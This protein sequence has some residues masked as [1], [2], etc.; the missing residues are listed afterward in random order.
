MQ[1]TTRIRI[2][3]QGVRPSVR[4]SRLSRERKPTRFLSSLVDVRVGAVLLG[5]C[6][7]RFLGGP[8]HGEAHIVPSMSPSVRAMEGIPTFYQPFFLSKPMV[9]NLHIFV[10][11]CLVE[12]PARLPACLSLSMRS[13]CAIGKHAPPR[14]APA[15]TGSRF[16]SPEVSGTVTY[17]LSEWECNC[18]RAG[19]TWNKKNYNSFV[20]ITIRLLFGL[21]T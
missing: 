14:S 20:Q 15:T 5:G 12:P 13:P 8:G 6:E 16:Q 1:K 17:L 19:H 9:K 3:I 10:P 21:L 7:T 4:P 18:G 2:I 11:A